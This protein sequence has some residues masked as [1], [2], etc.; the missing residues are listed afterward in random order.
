MGEDQQIPTIFHI[1]LQ[2]LDL[3]GSELVLR[4]SDDEQL[5][6]LDLLIIYGF[7]VESDLNVSHFLTL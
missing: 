1:L 7:F 6:F 4:S 5:R 3:G 2:V